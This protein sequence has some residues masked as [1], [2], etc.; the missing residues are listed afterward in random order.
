MTG[1]S[2]RR[3]FLRGLVSLPLIGGCVTLIGQPTAAAVPV[4][5]ALMA[6]YA[7]WLAF[8]AYR[9]GVELYGRE[10]Q[11]SRDWYEHEGPAYR[12]HKAMDMTG[13]RPSTR[14]AVVLS[15]VGCDWG[16]S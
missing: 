16:R 8:E 1:P 2:D 6:E 12:W 14:A 15:A 11:R 10:G 3:G 7:N 4:T 5:E 13:V 9:A